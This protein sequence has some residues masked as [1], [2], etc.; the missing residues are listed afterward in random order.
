MS[1]ITY[2]VCP[3]CNA[4]AIGHR[5]TAEDYTVSHQPFEIWE[6]DNCHLRFTQHIPD[7]VSIGAFYQSEAYVSHT[8]TK[9]GIINKLYHFIRK[10]TLK[11]KLA[12]MRSATGLQKGSI[13]DIGAGTGAFA[14]TMQQ[15]GWTVT[16]LEPDEATRQRA[17]ELYGL[18]LQPV[19]SLFQLSTAQF[20]AITMWHVLEHV[21]DLH[22]YVAQ[23]KRLLK[24]GGRLFIA[25][26]NYTSHDA[27]VY[28]QYWAAYDV[29]RHLYHFSPL[30]M[31]QLLQQYG[32]KV[33]DCKPMWFDSYY[34][35]MLSEQYKKG[36]NNLVSATWNG[37]VSNIKAVFKKERC[38]SLIYVIVN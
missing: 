34:V 18:T 2:K 16:A 12:L 5:L 24:P 15:A 35:A 38:S 9:E 11:G 37:L 8:D 26:P 22:G 6:C 28:K 36:H 21:H 33:P 27:A 14:N 25:V 30:S 31:Q 17:K 10:R 1:T 4:P 7:A 3:V 29:P 32:L 19:E 20:D 13:L 23:L